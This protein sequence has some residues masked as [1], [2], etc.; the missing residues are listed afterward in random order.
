MLLI[1]IVAALILLA[2]FAFRKQNKDAAPTPPQNTIR[3]PHCGSPA[4]VIGSRWE[5]GWCGDFGD[6][7]VK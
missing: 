2:V 6:I 3:C 7:S 4:R 1:V 5:C